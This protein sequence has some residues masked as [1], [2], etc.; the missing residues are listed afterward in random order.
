MINGFR[1][2]MM[3][4]MRGGRFAV[5]I[6]VMIALAGM[7]PVMFGIMNTMIEAMKGIYDD[8][9]FTQMFTL[10][11]N[12]TAA[13]IT[14]Y[15]VE[16]VVEFGAIV[17]LFVFRNSAGGEQ[18]KRSVIIP[19]CSG[20]TPARYILPKFAIYP[21]FMFIVSALSVYLGAGI[22]AV[23]FPGGLDW[24]MITVSACCSGV[25]LAF[26]TALQFCIGICTG[27]SGVTVAVVLIMEMFVPSILSLL[28]VDRFN[29][30]A[31]SSIAIYA[32]LANA[33]PGS[34]M[35]AS[36]SAVSTTPSSSEISSLNIAVS[37]G[38]AVVISVILCFVTLFVLNT[39][40][41]HNE[42]DEPVL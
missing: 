11:T 2:E 29:P 42:G 26:I 8:E 35:L 9:T 34:S 24:S 41:V 32:P 12:M 22:S 10:F 19:R 16:S 15:T 6:L 39:K 25:F 33:E 28:R 14:M 3:F 7:Y 31:L 20:L 4:F 13:D 37:I 21:L 17:M 18:Q 30:F 27:K 23:M 1:K 36:I 5:I 38:T 40:Q